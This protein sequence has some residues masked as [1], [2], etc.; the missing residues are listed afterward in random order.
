M[1]SESILAAMTSDSIQKLHVFMREMP[2]DLETPVSAFL[3]LKD[4]GATI[5]LESVESGANVGRYSFIGIRPDSRITINAGELTIVS[6]TGR[7]AI[8]HNGKDS[9][10]SSLK[11]ILTRFRLETSLPQPRLLG[12]AVERRAAA[13]TAGHQKTNVPDRPDRQPGKVGPWIPQCGGGVERAAQGG[14]S[15]R[16]A[17]PHLC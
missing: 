17:I 2:A 14:G 15:A 11:K 13:R 3:K 5:L 10:L 9:A 7:T 1:K 12:G 16:R 4:Y 6:D 8:A